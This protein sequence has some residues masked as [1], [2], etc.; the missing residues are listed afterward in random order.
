MTN[1]DPSQYGSAVASLLRRETLPALG[2]GVPDQAVEAR[3]RLLS[4]PKLFSDHAVVDDDMARACLAGLWLL[5]DFLDE[6]H[7]ISQ[8]INTTTG[9]YWHGIMHRREPDYENAKYWFRRVRQHPVFEPLLE[10]VQ[11]DSDES[12][13]IPELTALR[14][15]PTWDPFLFVDLCQQA[16]SANGQLATA[17][18]SIALREWQLLFDYSFR[19]AVGLASI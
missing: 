13:N 6:S 17:C 19:Q 2:P 1:F 18:R 4:L 16:A 5:H 14:T 11:A 10:S 9:S 15:K 12:F 3:L 8:E 7:T